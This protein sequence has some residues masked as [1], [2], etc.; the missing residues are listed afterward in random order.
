MLE[1]VRWLTV[2]SGNSSV[3]NNNVKFDSCW[4]ITGK[5]L[6]W[7]GIFGACWVLG[8]KTGE[9]NFCWVLG[10]GFGKT[11]LGQHWWCHKVK[12]H[13]F[14]LIYWQS[15]GHWAGSRSRRNS[16]RECRVRKT[17]PR[18]GCSAPRIPVYSST[19]D[20]DTRGTSH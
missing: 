19:E 14:Y 11:V 17:A 6:G 5:T 2:E 3:V 16:V 8:R 15:A 1:L 9:R 20:T 18:P 4:K 10:L 7:A 13:H 12:G